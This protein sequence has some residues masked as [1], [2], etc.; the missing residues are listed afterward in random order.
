MS[1]APRR[2]PS[3]FD[4]AGGSISGRRHVRAGRNN[5]DAFAWHATDTYAVAIVC[6]GCSSE[7]HSEVGAR[8]GATMLCDAI[9]SRVNG[10]GASKEALVGLVE[11]A[12]VDLLDR[13]RAFATSMGSDTRRTVYE[14]LLFTV[15]GVV[16]THEACVVF[17]LGDGAAWL[18]G[19]PVVSDALGACEGNAPAY[20]GYELLDPA[21]ERRFAVH[22]SACGTEVSM[23]AV[24]SD[25]A[26]D[27][28]HHG[29]ID[30][31]YDA[32]VFRNVDGMRRALVVAGRTRATLD[33]DTTLVVLRHRPEP[34]AP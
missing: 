3:A 17:G 1:A 33:D 9:V 34:E 13:L 4:V 14:H 2:S 29:R 18:D 8:L 7:P 28:A 31:L 10:G 21:N 22:G 23:V 16:W 15:V 20:L 5:Q 30:T 24:G 12:R 25:G 11:A 32:R 26:L 6:D 27:L 19:A